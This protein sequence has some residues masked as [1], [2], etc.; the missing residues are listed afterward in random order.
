M[1][2]LKNPKH[3]PAFAE[4]GV[5][6]GAAIK[7]AR[8]ALRVSATT[9]AEAADISRV[10]L[11][12]IERG[13]VS[14][15]IGAYLRAAD[16]LGIN[17]GAVAQQAQDRVTEPIATHLLDSIAIDQYPQLK[18]I[19]WSIPHAKEIKPQIALALYERNWRYIDQAAMQPHERA[20]L[21]QLVKEYGN[22]CLF[23]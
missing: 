23:I 12:R 2:A 9:A 1:E 15:N 21:N 11:H 22:G 6:I 7:A 8:K 19:A 20:L 14:V 16:A 13:D 4:A 18:M 17:I 5:R 10:T 3:T